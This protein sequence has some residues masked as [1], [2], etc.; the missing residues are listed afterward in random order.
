MEIKKNHDRMFRGSIP[1][2][3]KSKNCPPPHPP[4]LSLNCQIQFGPSSNHIELDQT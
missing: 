4:P 2:Y 1:E 3:V